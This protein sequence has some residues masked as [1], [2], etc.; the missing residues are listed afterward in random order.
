MKNPIKPQWIPR[1]VLWAGIPGAVL[2]ALYFATAV[3][4][5][6][7]LA[8]GH[9]ADILCWILTAVVMAVLALGIRSLGG[10]PKYEKLFPASLPG[11]IGTWLGAVGIAAASIRIFT[12]PADI[13]SLVTGG[14]GF[15]SVVCLAALGYWR[16]KG[17]KP[18]VLVRLPLILFCMLYLICQYRGW[19]SAT[20]LQEYAFPLFASVFLML[21]CYQRA[22]LEVR[23]GGRR[24]YVFCT[25]AA[26][27]F[28]L[29]AGAQ[30]PLFYL[31]MAVWMYLDICSLRLMQRKA[32]PAAQASPEAAPAPEEP[33]PEGE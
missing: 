28:C 26:A 21:S 29:L 15:A 2:Q 18:P 14:F 32:K 22:A 17:Q 33:K 30:D 16:L 12:A 25:Q 19:S 8:R 7:L 9:F 4:E 27:Y 11:A 23:L 10:I 6:G 24:T 20:Q 3:D 31:P 13:F 1:C 5:K